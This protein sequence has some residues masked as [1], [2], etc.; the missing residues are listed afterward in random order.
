MLNVIK[1]TYKVI[2]TVSNLCPGFISISILSSF[3]QGMTSIIDILFLNYLMISIQNDKD[4]SLL[5]CIIVSLFL[6]QY[7]FSVLGLKF[8]QLIIPEYTTKLNEKIQ[9]CI[10]KKIKEVDYQCYEDKDFYNTLTSTIQQSDS[11]MIAIVNTLSSFL[12]NIF[13][14]TALI[15]ILVWID[16]LILFFVMID[17]II[18]I[19]L[20]TVIS[21]IKYKQYVSSLEFNR[22]LSYLQYLFYNVRNVKNLKLF[23][24]FN[25][26]LRNKYTLASSDIIKITKEYYMKL[27]LLQKIQLFFSFGMNTLSIIYLTFKALN[28]LMNI[29]SF[30]TA[31]NSVNQLK[32]NF[33]NIATVIP[34]L[35][36]HSKYIEVF[37]D[38]L[39]SE[40]KIEKKNSKNV[41]SKLENLELKDVWFK[42][43]DTNNW[44]LKNFSI[45]LKKGEK[46]AFVGRNGV[47]KSTLLKLVC[48]FYNPTFGEIYYNDSNVKDLDTFQLRNQISIVFQEVDFYATTIIE[49]V[50]MRKIDK[51]DEDEKIA[52][53]ALRKVGLL[54]KV[55]RLEDGIYTDLS[56]EFNQ[57]GTFFSGGEYQK[58]MIARAYAKK[59]SIII[60]DEPSSSLDAIAEKEI[61]EDAIKTFDN[62][63]LIFV[64]HK[65]ANIKNV[66]RIY[67]VEEGSIIEQGTHDELI[68]LNGKYAELFLLQAHEYI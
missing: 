48:R 31:M 63:L 59:G 40:P 1:N 18:T 12:S 3:L 28:Q 51:Q 61:F 53:E 22:K 39:N 36:E 9:N 4:I 26:S 15:S 35:Y 65:L 21:K 66:D 5:L 60:F 7:A 45:K 32:Y 57:N 34:S 50:L 10:F 17:V 52:I 64:T 46:I 44:V 2:K 16:K 42:Y 58:L 55:N 33:I 19:I 13:S 24:G 20:N 11:R 38:F 37:D 43:P 41:I 54:E 30:I 49:N 27:K 67:Y 8:Q 14:I 68:M 56:K 23:K 62:Q 29:S 47:G 6:I 25:E